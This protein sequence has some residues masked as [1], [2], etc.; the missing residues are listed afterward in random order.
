VYTSVEFTI[1][2][3]T[4]FYQE[5]ALLQA[6]ID[7]HLRQLNTASVF[8]AP[9]HKFLSVQ[10]NGLLSAPNRVAVEVQRGLTPHK[11]QGPLLFVMLGL[12]YILHLFSR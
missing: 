8:T 1:L 4:L 3:C 11:V 6:L 12:W 5:L 10:D 9:Y 2:T 7:E